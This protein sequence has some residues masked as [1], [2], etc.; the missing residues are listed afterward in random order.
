MHF[1]NTHLPFLEQDQRKSVRDQTTRE[2]MDSF[3]KK[4]KIDTK[5]IIDKFIIGD[6]II[7]LISKQIH[8][9][10]INL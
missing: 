7:V 2:T 4:L 9:V 5:S 1:I 3:Q 8:Q 10:N 6:L